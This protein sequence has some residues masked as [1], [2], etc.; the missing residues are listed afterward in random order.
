MHY[1][2]LVEEAQNTIYESDEYKL[3]DLKYDSINDLTVSKNYKQLSEIYNCANLYINYDFSTFEEEGIF[4]FKYFKK[5]PHRDDDKYQTIKKYACKFD[6]SNK[7]DKLCTEQYNCLTFELAARVPQN[8]KD[9]E[10]VVRLYTKDEKKVNLFFDL[11]FNRDNALKKHNIQE[12]S[13]EEEKELLIIA[14]S[15]NDKVKV[16]KLVQ[17]KYYNHE[18]EMFKHWSI[19]PKIYKII[20]LLYECFSLPVKEVITVI[21]ETDS[22]V[23][24]FKTKKTYYYDIDRN[25]QSN[26][27]KNYFQDKNHYIKTIQFTETYHLEHVKKLTNFSYLVQSIALAKPFDLSFM[28]YEDNI[29]YFNLNYTSATKILVPVYYYPDLSSQSMVS[30][31]INA[32]SANTNAIHLFDKLYTSLKD[33]EALELD[34]DSGLFDTF[35]FEDM[36]STS[37]AEDLYYYD[38]FHYRQEQQKHIIQ[39]LNEL[40]KIPQTK[41][42]NIFKKNSDIKTRNEMLEKTSLISEDAV[43][44]KIKKIRDV[45]KLKQ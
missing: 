9:M 11:I 14:S 17:Y 44:K 25:N 4:F 13:R 36:T 27:Q 43:R 6:E 8:V 29:K 31:E 42:K 38:Y 40:I 10:E 18:T 26:N 33:L 30:V 41:F 28:N 1:L 2:D 21:G 7:T 16:L 20:N 19:N 3:E 22:E 45:L 32:T 34:E 15:L 37:I 35:L 12:L 5:I 23:L 24:Q 39:Y